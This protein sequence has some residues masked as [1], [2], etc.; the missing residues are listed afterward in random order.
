V[1]LLKQKDVVAQALL[2]KMMTML[3]QHE[4]VASQDRIM[5]EKG[6]SDEHLA[7]LDGMCEALEKTKSKLRSF[8]DAQQDMHRVLADFKANKLGAGAY[9]TEA[10][11]AKLERYMRVNK[12]IDGRCTE[13][14]QQTPLTPAITQEVNP[15][16]QQVR[17]HLLHHVARVL[18]HRAEAHRHQR[19]HVHRRSL[20]LVR[21]AQALVQQL[22]VRRR[23]H[24]LPAAL[25]HQRRIRPLG[26]RVQLEPQL[27]EALFANHV[28][29]SRAVER[30][31]ERVHKRA[32]A[33]EHH[34]LHARRPPLFYTLAISHTKQVEPLDQ[35]DVKD[36]IVH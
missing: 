19:A 18:R 1:S 30:Q 9:G 35:P 23:Q 26:E 6:M 22:R 31:R 28:V 24:A 8:E 16:M 27:P 3:D 33:L 14:L 7:L 2:G 5:S 36:F 20:A 29:R 15:F 34:A 21:D 13:A 10:M 12:D 11:E 32:E 17:V 4:N 25:R